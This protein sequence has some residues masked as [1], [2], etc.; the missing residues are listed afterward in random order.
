MIEKD[1]KRL[2]ELTVDEWIWVVFIILSILNIT[3]DECEK[4]Y[5]RYHEVN[6]KSL[7]KKIFKITVFVSFLIYFYLSIKNYN[8]YKL[9]K[10]NNEDVS[11]AI[12]RYFASVLVVIASFIF[13]YA[14]FKDSE[15]IDPSID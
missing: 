11:L 12:S 4:K 14:Q 7:S 5:C 9:L 1:R 2:T 15:P 8:K 3:G 13:L 10:E 6:A